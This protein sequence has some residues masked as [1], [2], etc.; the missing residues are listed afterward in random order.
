[1]IRL[2]PVQ[3]QVL[4]AMARLEVELGRY[5][6][7]LEEILARRLTAMAK[8]DPKNAYFRSTATALSQLAEFVPRLV[9]ST[10]LGFTLSLAGRSTAETQL[11]IRRTHGA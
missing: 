9:S 1:M 8:T 5:A 11:G 3:Q 2:T 6:F 4:A 7:H 10:E